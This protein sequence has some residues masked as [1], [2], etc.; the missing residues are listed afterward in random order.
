M[1]IKKSDFVS[2][3]LKI[4]IES[5]LLGSMFPRSGYAFNYKRDISLS[6]VLRNLV[7]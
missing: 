6:Q 4:F 2:F 7:A 1:E 5:F 3:D